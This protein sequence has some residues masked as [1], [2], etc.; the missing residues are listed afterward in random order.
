MP[1]QSNMHTV[2]QAEKII[3]DH[4][5][6]LGWEE[7]SLNESLGRI[8][9]E[10]LTADRDFPPFDRVTMDG[11]AIRYASFEQGQ[12]SFHIEGVQAAGSAQLSLTNPA[13][14]LEVMT[15]AMLPEGADTVIPYENLKIESGAAMIQ[16]EPVKFRQNIHFQGIDRKANDAIVP[17][18][19]KIGPAEIATA[20]TVGK[21]RIR[22]AR[23]PRTAIISTGDE[24]VGVDQTPL[25]HQIR[26]SN[27]FAI[28]ALLQDQFQLN[29]RQFHFPDDREAIEQGLAEIFNSFD[30][31][32][33]SGAV[34]AGKYDF[35]PQILQNLGVEKCFHKVSQRPGKP[36]WFGQ[37]PGRAVIFAFPGNPVS[38]F[39]CACRYLVPF[40][41]QSSDQNPCPPEWAMLMEKVVFNPVLTYFLPV[42][43]ISGSDGILQ[44]YPL[45]GQGS[46]D[47]ANLNDAD[48]FLELPLEQDVFLPGSV[49]LL[50]RYRY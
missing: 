2:S 15:G 38:A 9:W 19:K 25:P 28:H 18:G 4:I 1:I 33:L 3:F 48:G 36:F 43:L 34:S 42:R 32:I 30:L 8:L 41:R 5:L 13:N 50:H 47:L 11:I 12:R 49:F 46:G 22:V 24:L 35:V 40:L 26:A 27:V 45:P 39:M 29:S 7:V 20:A 14:C 37:L 10:D 31:I 17:K 21:S 44:A 23:L 6:N 16:S